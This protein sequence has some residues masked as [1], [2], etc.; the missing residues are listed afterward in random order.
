MDPDTSKG[1]RLLYE[2]T[3]YNRR[4]DFDHI[5]RTR[6]WTS[7]TCNIKS[8]RQ[9]QDREKGL[10]GI[11]HPYWQD[12]RDHLKQYITP[13]SISKDIFKPY[14][15]IPSQETVSLVDQYTKS[16]WKQNPD[17]MY[18]L[19]PH[20]PQLLLTPDRIPILRFCTHRTDGK[21]IYQDGT[22]IEPSTAYRAFHGTRQFLVPHILK[23]GLKSSIHSHKIIGTWANLSTDE[24][25][26]W[27]SSIY[28]LFPCIAVEFFA[29]L[30]DIRSNQNIKQGNPNRLV[31]KLAENQQLPAIYIT[32]ILVAFPKPDRVKIHG[33]LLEV[34]KTS[35]T[36]ISRQSSI[37]KNQDIYTQ[38]W[39]ISAFRYAYANNKYAMV[40]QFGG[41]ESHAYECVL[42]PSIQFTRILYALVELTNDDNRRKKLS[43]TDFQVL[44]KPMKL[45]LQNLY[46]NIKDW[47]SQERTSNQTKLSLLSA[48]VVQLI[49]WGPVHSYQDAID[50]KMIADD[51]Q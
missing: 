21:H 17:N 38:L 18:N 45:F 2:S 11:G 10:P 44:P 7:T 15:S 43:Q 33:E 29:P 26:L 49:T 13:P 8:S 1:H 30:R 50:L 41:L 36:E 9:P 6:N 14:K 16:A 25:L 23:Q 28:D 22:Q 47:T 35:A 24:A 20:P 27:T 5:L 12:R 39:N 40:Q 48:T 51:Q 3:P 19:H 37:Q 34:L 31:V 4:A 42:E 46:P 32:A